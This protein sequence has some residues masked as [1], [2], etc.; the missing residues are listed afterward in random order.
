MILLAVVLRYFNP[1][2]PCGARLMRP[3]G[4][5]MTKM[6]SIH[7]PRAGRD[8]ACFR[9]LSAHGISIHAPRAG[10]DDTPSARIPASCH[11]NPRAPC[12]A[13]PLRISEISALKWISIH[14]PRAG[15][16]GD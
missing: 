16:D 7:A 2:A 4:G 5:D 9:S 15:R 8:L 1:R 12:G 14:A 11:F 6:I 10:R 3:R 13:R